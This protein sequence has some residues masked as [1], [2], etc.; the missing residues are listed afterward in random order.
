M[1]VTYG[2][3]NSV[4]GDRKYNAE[5]ISEFFR[6]I[7][8]EGVYQ[9]LDGGLAVTAG[10]GLAVNVGAGRAIIQDRWIQNSAAMSLT[11]AAASETYARKDAVVIR[12]NWSS[13]AISI[14]VK[15]GTP[16]AS[17][18][19]P[20]M[21]RNSTT[22]EMALAYV[23]V[24]ANATSVTVT[25]KRSDSTVCGW[26]TVAQAT[27]GEVDAQL[28]AMKTGF[29][30]VT[31]ASPAAQVQGSD[32]K[33]INEINEAGVR[34]TIQRPESGNF[35]YYPYILV[36]GQTYRIKLADYKPVAAALV[37]IFT[38][39]DNQAVD[40]TT[41]F[42]DFTPVKTGP[43]G[44]YITGTWA[45]YP[46]I[47]IDGYVTRVASDADFAASLANNKAHNEHIGNETLGLSWTECA[48]ISLS[49]GNLILGYPCVSSEMITAEE[50]M[51][52]SV[53][54]HNNGNSNA[55]GGIFVYSGEGTSINQEPVSGEEVE[56]CASCQAGRNM[57][58]SLAVKINGTNIT[59]KN[60]ILSYFDV[61]VSKN[62]A[63]G[64]Y[65]IAK[66]IN[67]SDITKVTGHSLKDDGS[68]VSQ[69][70]FSHTGFI[71]IPNGS[72]YIAFSNSINCPSQICFY[73]DDTEA[74]FV[75]EQGTF[76]E[77]GVAD[78]PGVL[79][80][81][82]RLAAYI[83]FSCDMNQNQFSGNVNFFAPYKLGALLPQPTNKADYDEGWI[84]D[85][86]T[87]QT[88]AYDGKYEWY[89]EVA[90]I[91]GVRAYRAYGNM[92]WVA[93]YDSEWNFLGK[94]DGNTGM[95]PY[96]LAAKMRQFNLPENTAYLRIPKYLGT[97]S[98]INQAT[99]YNNPY[100]SI[101]PGYENGHIYIINPG[102]KV[103]S[104][105]L[106][107]ND[108]KSEEGSVIAGTNIHFM[109]PVNTY[110]QDVDSDTL[111]LQDGVS[112]DYDPSV[113]ML[114][115]TYTD[116]GKPTR[117]IICC[118]GAGGTVSTDDSQVENNKTVRYLVANG[119]AV[120]DTNGIPFNYADTNGISRLNNVGSWLAMECYKNAYNYVMEKY[121]LYKD[122]V[123]LEGGSMGGIS[124]TN[125]V[126]CSQLPVIAHG[127]YCPV[128][129]TYNE[130][131]LHPW[132]GGLPKTALAKLFDFDQ[133]GGQYVYDE[134]KLTGFNPVNNNTVEVDGTK[135]TYYPCPVKFWHCDNDTTVNPQITA[136][137]VQQIK[138]AGG[139]AYLRK[140][141]S[142]GH[143]PQDA[144]DVL[145]NPSGN[146]NYRGTTI[147]VRPAM[148]ELLIW[149]NRFNQKVLE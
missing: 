98:D 78:H 126:M 49:N 4:N 20:S 92:I 130:I 108:S 40:I 124:S 131:W 16:A 31:Y 77:N 88:G 64:I 58:V 6:G 107:G 53:K 48:G 83:R 32:I 23:N 120:L 145:V 110:R 14:A 2:F 13:R 139:R 84:K 68:S 129:D 104:E 52:I 50:D 35:K 51:T 91:S 117:L 3:F 22:Y 24:A 62:T 59:D 79:F 17:P 147:E 100:G 125:L 146:T 33:I 36:A 112:I 85:D 43:I 138:N 149:F 95:N 121:N 41:D 82:P 80:R 19:A 102:Q 87:I 101:L 96:E 18:V 27:S 71:A 103:I 122:G 115:D 66:S 128:L 142:G 5:Q 134:D 109:T 12:L 94:S 61:W 73:S 118:H 28:N 1:A 70:G 26:A 10:T 34:F 60:E 89:Y 63:H 39:P 37:K 30:G 42:V 29:D 81:I 127:A 119:Y 105:F 136:T 76:A 25:D 11:I 57:R 123:F 55:T 141:P 111:N 99:S 7:I 148:E 140:L 97:S 114:P 72:E 44:T 135:Y 67:I 69:S 47:I 144:G 56:Y 9:H 8:N 45:Y 74:S 116:S 46:D 21:T 75:G 15:T 133:E 65:S 106:L 137:F 143:E 90:N 132:S 38:D 54:F 113:L 93:C 86:G